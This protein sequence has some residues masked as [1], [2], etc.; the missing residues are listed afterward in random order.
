M[1]KETARR[2]F[3][4]SHRKELLKQFEGTTTV[5]ASKNAGRRMLR[6]KKQKKLFHILTIESIV[7]NKMPP[8]S[9]DRQDCVAIG[10]SRQMSGTGTL[11]P[12]AYKYKVTGAFKANHMEKALLSFVCVCVRDRECVSVCVCVIIKS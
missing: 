11:T 8:K 10:T 4:H 2:W 1:N 9:S 12:R 7:L 6:S 5:T 3:Q